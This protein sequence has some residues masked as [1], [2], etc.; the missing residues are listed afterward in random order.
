MKTHTWRLILKIRVEPDQII[1]DFDE[2]G[3]YKKAYG[4]DITVIR[5][6]GV[7]D[8]WILVVS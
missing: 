4:P 6:I 3:W 2:K 8:G 1:K 5:E 7:P